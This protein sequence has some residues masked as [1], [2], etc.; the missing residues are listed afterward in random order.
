MA[1]SWDHGG[2][3][4]HLYEASQC[5]N[6]T[7]QVLAFGSG[8]HAGMGGSFAIIEFPERSDPDVL[9]TEG[10]TGQAYIEERDR[11]VRARSETFDL[12]RATALPPVDSARLIRSISAESIK[13]T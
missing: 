11:E 7:L 4:D 1:P 10:V 9:Y 8:L 13:S 12:L 6:I 3:L 2:Q 5:P